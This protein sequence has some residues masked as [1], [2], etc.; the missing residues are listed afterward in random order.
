MSFKPLFLPIL[1][2]TLLLAVAD[3][4]ARPLPSEGIVERLNAERSRIG[5]P[6]DV[7]LDRPASAGC[8]LHN[9][10]MRMNDRVQHSEPPHTRGY[11]RK[12]H[13]AGMSSVL[14]SDPAGWRVGNPWR[15]APIHLSQVYNPGLRS[16]GTSDAYGHSCMSTWP[17]WEEPLV[18]RQT[19]WTF[20][21]N[22][23]KAPF[24]QL[25]WEAPYLPQQKV[26][27]PESRT[28]GPYLYV[29]TASPQPPA[30]PDWYPQPIGYTET[31][32]PIYDESKQRYD[33]RIAQIENW[34]PPVARLVSGSVVSGGGTAVPVKVIDDSVV[35]SYVGEGNGWLLPV[36]PLNRRTAY[37]ATIV[38]APDAGQAN[39]YRRTYTW[40]FRTTGKR[41]RP[42]HL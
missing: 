28:T 8:A 38:L 36:R 3:A 20:P 41:L 9:R 10:W 31:G 24:A 40:T 15:N 33:E 12:G 19:V 2:V 18:T 7:R 6:A 16:S 29:W 25:G 39:Q 11:T 21:A 1:L 4:S 17:G 26:G 27:I 35:D 42:R 34:P 32:E 14:S 5:L 37:R 23:G 22:G 30:A 13:E